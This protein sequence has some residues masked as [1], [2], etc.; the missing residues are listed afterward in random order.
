LWRGTTD[1][2]MT[3][4]RSLMPLS[5][6]W[7]LSQF[8]IKHSLNLLQLM[9]VQTGSHW[10]MKT[11]C[12]PERHCT[13]EI[14]KTPVSCN[15]WPLNL[16]TVMK[17]DTHESYFSFNHAREGKRKLKATLKKWGSL[18]VVW[19]P[20]YLLLTFPSPPPDLQ[21]HSFYARPLPVDAGQTPECRPISAPSDEPINTMLHAAVNNIASTY[22]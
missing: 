20:Q 4:N 21:C 18:N 11:A 15:C 14:C 10:R 16:K 1:S 9:P 19:Q 6:I 17:I 13:L 2:P 5:K 3:I 22:T 12:K 8:I 7:S